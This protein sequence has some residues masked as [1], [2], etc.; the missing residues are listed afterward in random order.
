MQSKYKT[1][2]ERYKEKKRRKLEKYQD[3][4]KARLRAKEAKKS[5][6]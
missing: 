4:Q 6:G 5:S 1:P 2:L 3:P